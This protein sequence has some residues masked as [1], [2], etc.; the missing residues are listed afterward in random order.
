MNLILFGP[1][2]AGKGTQ[3]E[4]ISKNFQMPHI[5]TGDMLRSAIKN[6]TDFGLKAKSM[7]ER[8]ELVSDDI[9]LGI[10]E[11]RLKQNDCT[12]GFILDGFPRTIAQAD[13]LSTI[14]DKLDQKLDY[15][16]ALDV[17]DDVIVKRLSGRRTCPACGKGY[18]ILYESPVNEGLCNVCNTPLVQRDDDTEETVINRLKVYKEQ[19]EPLVEYY[20]I[21]K[22]LNVVSGHGTISDIQQ[23]INTILVNRS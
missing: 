3:A 8:G 2:G 9:V 19:T 5:S 14:L 7:M 6:G 11:E 22:I 4:F 13:A 20:R 10:V 23:R 21:N 16:L 12:N 1:P 17:S 18:H 15:V